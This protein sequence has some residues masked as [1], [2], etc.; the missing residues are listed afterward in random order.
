ML[1]CTNK[2]TGK[3]KTVSMLTWIEKMVYFKYFKNPLY[4]YFMRKETHSTHLLDHRYARVHKRP[5][6]QNSVGEQT[7]HY[8]FILFLSTANMLMF[9]RYKVYHLSLVC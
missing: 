8:F 6:T 2:K 9:G 4:K 3:K 1:Q 5:F 7:F